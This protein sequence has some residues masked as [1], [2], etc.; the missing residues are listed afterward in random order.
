M[1]GQC[2]CNS[3]AST[4]DVMVQGTSTLRR[5]SDT[6]LFF[7]RRIELMRQALFELILD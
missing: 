1:A 6:D 3:T 2:I 4:S 5:N 7:L